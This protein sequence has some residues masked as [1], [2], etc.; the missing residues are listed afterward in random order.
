MFI[1]QNVKIKNLKKVSEGIVAKPN[2]A[3]ANSKTPVEG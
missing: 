2:L 3:F 1:K